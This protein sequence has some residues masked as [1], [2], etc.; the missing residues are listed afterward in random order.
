MID[1]KLHSVYFSHVITP[2]GYASSYT[3]IM[4]IFAISSKFGPHHLHGDFR[5]LPH[6][7]PSPIKCSLMM[8]ARVTGFHRRFAHRKGTRVAIAGDDDLDGSYPR[9]LVPPA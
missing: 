7:K 5:K 4:E 2:H 1:R 3:Q 8:R 6:S 9:E